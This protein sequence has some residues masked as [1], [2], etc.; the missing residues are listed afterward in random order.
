LWHGVGLRTHLLLGSAN[1]LFWSSFVQQ[2]LVMVGV[3]TTVWHIVSGCGCRWA[4]LRRGEG[5]NIERRYS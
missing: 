3:V 5:Y 4:T 2:G 1:I